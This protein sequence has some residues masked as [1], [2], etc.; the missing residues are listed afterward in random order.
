MANLQFTRADAEVNG[1]KAKLIT[2]F[3]VDIDNGAKW[4]PTFGGGGNSF[5]ALQC[6][7][8]F[9]YK[10]AANAPTN[11]PERNWPGYVFN[12]T[13]ISA[14]FKLP[15]G[16]RIVFAGAFSKFGGKSAVEG[17]TDGSIDFV[18]TAKLV[19]A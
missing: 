10:L 11:A 2:D 6:S 1:A 15:G 19:T 17:A 7:G 3:S 4:E 18:G 8:S 13:P 16:N 14:V 12:K 9:S 5:G